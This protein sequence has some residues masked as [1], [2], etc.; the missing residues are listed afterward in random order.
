MVS[1]MEKDQPIRDLKKLET[2]RQQ[3]AK[4]MD[5]VR[6]AHDGTN[7][8]FGTLHEGLRLLGVPTER[9]GGWRA[10]AKIR[11]RRQCVGCSLM[12]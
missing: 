11:G 6:G 8:F 3:L 10:S 12:T 2:L 7:S 9:F 4:M 1:V 5:E